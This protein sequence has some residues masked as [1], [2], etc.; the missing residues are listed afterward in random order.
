MKTLIGT[1]T[2]GVALVAALAVS[3]S[4]MAE[5]KLAGAGATFPAPLYKKWVVEFEKAM[6]G[7]KFDYNSI[8]SGGGIKAIT[9]KTVAFGASD[10][11]LSKKEI[12]ALGGEN[13]VTQIPTCAGAVVPAYNVPGVTGDIN[14]T[15]EVIA[16][17]FMGKITKWNDKALAD[18]NPGMKLPDLA[19]TPAYRTD[20]SGTTFV[21]TSYLATQ[22]EEYKSSIGA[23][24]QVKWP[25]G[26][27]GK[28]NEGVAAAIQQT[29]GGFGYI[30]ANYANS[31]KIAYGAVKNAAGKFVKA[32]AD[33]VSASGSNAV[34]AFKGNQLVADIWNQPG[35]SAYPISAFTYIIVYTDLGNLKTA[36]E[37]AALV[38]FLK[39]ATTDGQSTAKSMDYAPLAGP[40]QTKVAETIAKL[41][42]QGK[43][44]SAGAKA[45]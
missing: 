12:E 17:I 40:V 8:G 4:V 16:K 6:P 2:R 23:G 43:P 14:F 31:N 1:V 36:E 19:I 45:H 28:G 42:F 9:D 38:G 13:A 35:D 29:A 32:T 44:V 18:L 21:F 15:G 37:A 24:K 30:E 39:W 41:T 5:T 7:V 20:G 10:A 22:S 33:A 26:T 27:G 34:T 11:P 25:L 3:T